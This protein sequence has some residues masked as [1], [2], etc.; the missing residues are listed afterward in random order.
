MN[1]SPILMTCQIIAEMDSRVRRGQMVWILLG[2]EY[3]VGYDTD[4]ESSK[5]F[6]E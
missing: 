5:T 2:Y 4:I 6:S 1:T 3:C